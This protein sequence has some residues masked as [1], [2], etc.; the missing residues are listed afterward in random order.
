[1]RSECATLEHHATETTNDILKEIIEDIS[2]LEKDF[3]KLQ[4]SDVNE[5]NHLRQQTNTLVQEKMVLT[6]D[7]NGLDRRI[8]SIERDVGFE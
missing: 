8:T 1:L 3:F 7:A 6:Q 2:N 5:M 4:Q